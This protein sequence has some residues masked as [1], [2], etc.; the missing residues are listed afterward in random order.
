MSQ[1]YDYVR[2]VLIESSLNPS[3]FA[4]LE[5]WIEIARRVDVVEPTAMCVSTVGADGRPSA[6]FVLLRDLD[7][8][9]LTFFTNY[10]SRKGRE[11][12]QNPFACAT[13]WWGSL[14]RQVRV[15]GRVEKVSPDESDA[16]FH[17]R[18][19]QSQFASAASPQSQ[20]VQS[21]EELESAV[22][23]LAARY[24]EGDMPRPESWGGYRLIPD[25]F[26]FWQ[27]RPAR[28]HD[29]LVYTLGGDQWIIHRLAP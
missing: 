12:A 25:R 20:V 16:Y 13:F 18:P 23:N 22:A 10:E 5:G 29:R 1:R 3:P 19:R 21:R 9:G 6:R 7:E 11:L 24:P 26:E 17:S 27:G 4:E 14:E 28:L 2:G 8:R 15:E